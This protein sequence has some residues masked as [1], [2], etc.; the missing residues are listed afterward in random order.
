MKQIMTFTVAMMI[1]A[2]GQLLAADAK[3][4]KE[5]RQKM[6]EMHTKMAACLKSDKPMSDCQ[7]DM[8][9]NCKEMMGKGGCPMMGQMK[10]MMNG[11]G[12]MDSTEQ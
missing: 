10:G 8:M 7:K 12:M 2:A 5:D 11:P 9:S 6:A 4:S 3:V 1:L